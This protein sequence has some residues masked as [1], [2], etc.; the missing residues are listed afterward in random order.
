MDAIKNLFDFFLFCLTISRYYS[1]LCFAKKKGLSLKLFW[2]EI[3]TEPMMFKCH[4]TVFLV[5][6]EEVIF[7]SS[8]FILRLKALLGEERHLLDKMI[9]TLPS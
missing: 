7:C 5:P 6:Q 1:D 9:E 2:L 3:A 8:L 4:L